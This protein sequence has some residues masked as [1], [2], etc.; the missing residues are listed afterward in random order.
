MK[1]LM[2]NPGQIPAKSVLLDRIGE[3]TP[4]GTEN[5][6]KTHISNLRGKL[7]DTFGKDYIEAVWGIGFRLNQES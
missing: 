1:L 3:D 6:L 2:R 5:S 4:D 7:R